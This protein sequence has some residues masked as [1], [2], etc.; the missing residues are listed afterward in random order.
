VLALVLLWVVLR[1]DWLILMTLHW[2]LLLAALC[3][4]WVQ[5]E[6]KAVCS[7]DASITAQLQQEASKLMSLPA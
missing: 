6:L 4:W 3:L 1:L 2:V 5:A 7:R